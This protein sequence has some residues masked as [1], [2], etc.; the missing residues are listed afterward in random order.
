MLKGVKE[1]L[2]EIQD[3]NIKCCGMHGVLFFFLIYEID[4][5]SY[6]IFFNSRNEFSEHFDGCYSKVATKSA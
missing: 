3:L 6:F 4:F 5:T 1:L 2:M